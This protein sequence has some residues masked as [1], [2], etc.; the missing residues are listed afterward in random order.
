MHED[1]RERRMRE[2]DLRARVREPRSRIHVISLTPS[3]LP[4]GMDTFTDFPSP[5]GRGQRVRAGVPSSPSLLPE[6]E[7]SE[8]SALRAILFTWGEGR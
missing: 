4:T 7:G 5:F 6:G 8:P 2:R 3:P 1:Y